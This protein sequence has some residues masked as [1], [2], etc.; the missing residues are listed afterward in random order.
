MRVENEWLQIIEDTAKPRLPVYAHW[1]ETYISSH[2]DLH[3]HACSA[4]D[5]RM[6]L[7]FDL[8]TSGSTGA[9]RMPCTVRLPTLVLIARVVFLLQHGLAHRQTQTY[10]LTDALIAVPTHRVTMLTS[11]DLIRL[12]R[13]V[14]FAST[15]L[16][17]TSLLL[18]PFWLV[19]LS[20]FMSTAKVLWWWWM[21]WFSHLHCF[22][23]RLFPI[24]KTQFFS[25]VWSL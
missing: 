2:I 9:E 18:W 22:T 12:H 19:K 10:K 20:D 21:W 17:R 1:P 23:I 7:A 14:N 5:N 25:H 6:T 13:L 11:S 24:S 4:F 15:Q 8:P 3:T 16:P